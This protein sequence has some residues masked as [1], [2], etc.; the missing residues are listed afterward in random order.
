MKVFSIILIVVLIVGLSIL[1][2]TQLVGLIKDIRKRNMKK[3]EINQNVNKE[4]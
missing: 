3:K 2:V 1:A 4:E